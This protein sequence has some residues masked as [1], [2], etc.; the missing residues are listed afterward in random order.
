MCRESV[1]PNSHAFFFF[2]EISLPF[3]SSKL[4]SFMFRLCFAS[5]AQSTATLSR[6]LILLCS[7]VSTFLLFDPSVKL[8]E[9]F[10]I[11]LILWFYK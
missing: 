4:L 7:C 3:L 8:S 10:I 5:H 2:L 9:V 11:L 1:N 6:A